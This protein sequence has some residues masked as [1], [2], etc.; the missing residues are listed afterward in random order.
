MIS[1]RIHSNYYTL[2]YISTRDNSPNYRREPDENSK[3]LR[4][5]YRADQ[6]RL[7]RKLNRDSIIFD[8]SER[9]S[10]IGH[11][12]IRPVRL[13]DEALE[14]KFGFGA[15][16]DAHSSASRIYIGLTGTRNGR[17]NERAGKGRGRETQIYRGVNYETTCLMTRSDPARCKFST[18]G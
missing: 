3:M 17:I 6:A 1:Y 12:W 10:L 4:D 15:R 13:I 18:R 14:S 2:V 7:T 16:L 8:K 5:T 9:S 11:P